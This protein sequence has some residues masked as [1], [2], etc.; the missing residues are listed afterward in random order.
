M[1]PAAYKVSQVPGAGVG[2]VASRDLLPGEF[3]LTFFT[4]SCYHIIVD[5]QIFNSLKL[6][7]IRKSYLFRGADPLGQPEHLVS[8]DQMSSPVLAVLPNSPKPRLC[9][10][11][12]WVSTLWTRLSRGRPAQVREIQPTEKT[13]TPFRFTKF[14]F[15]QDWMQSVWTGRL[16]GRDWRPQCGGRSLC[17][18]SSFTVSDFFYCALDPRNLL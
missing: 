18:H 10:R 13:F 8:P 2:L 6:S 3:I 5:H 7:F 1:S 17:C 16:R 9:L 12:L 11:P 15:T 14:P 4:I